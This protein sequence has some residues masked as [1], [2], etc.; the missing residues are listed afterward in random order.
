M[1][2]GDEALG[3]QNKLDMSRVTTICH[4]LIFFTLTCLT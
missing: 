3:R 4:A 1:D 2:L